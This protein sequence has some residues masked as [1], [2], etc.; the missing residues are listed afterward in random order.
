MIYQISYAQLQ[1]FI[2]YYHTSDNCHVVVLHY[3][4]N[5]LQVTYFSKLYYNTLL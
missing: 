2:S 5:Y 4:K 1:W 3:T